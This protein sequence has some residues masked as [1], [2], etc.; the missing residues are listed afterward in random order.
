MNID[1]LTRFPARVL[2]EIHSEAN[3]KSQKQVKEVPCSDE[4][5]S[6]QCKQPELIPI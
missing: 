1:L 3:S 2:D 4:G 5:S 6:E